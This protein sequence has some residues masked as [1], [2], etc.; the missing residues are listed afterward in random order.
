MKSEKEALY[1]AAIENSFTATDDELRTF[2]DE[3]KEI[4]RT[5]ANKEQLQPV[6]DSF[7]SEE[8]FWAHEYNVARKNLPIIK[9][10]N[11]LEAEYAEEIG[12]DPSTDTFYNAWLEQFEEIKKQLVEEQN[13]VIQLSLDE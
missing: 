13:F 9:Y 4:F 11:S 12:A 10:Q 6:I 3:Q 2:I 1:A 7:E 8:A 5:A